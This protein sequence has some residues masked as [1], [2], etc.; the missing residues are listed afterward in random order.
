MR[1]R[2]VRLA[3]LHPVSRPG[4]GGGSDVMRLRASTL[5]MYIM[6]YFMVTDKSLVYYSIRS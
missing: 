1:T 4:R 2:A 5:V 6:I 3:L